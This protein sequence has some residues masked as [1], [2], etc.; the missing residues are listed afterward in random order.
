MSSARIRNARPSTTDIIENTCKGTEILN[1]IHTEFLPKFPRVRSYFNCTEYTSIRNYSWSTSPR[2]FAYSHCSTLTAPVLTYYKSQ[3]DSQYMN[4]PQMHHLQAMKTLLWYLKETK[5]YRMLYHHHLHNPT[6][7]LPTIYSDANF[8]N[9]TNCKSI[10]GN[11]RLHANKPIFRVS[12]SQNVVDH[13]NEYHATYQLT[14]KFLGTS[15]LTMRNN[16][17]PSH[18]QSVD[19]INCQPPSYSQMH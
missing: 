7:S 14:P 8:V 6:Q 13:N 18:R 5:S 4:K 16:N 2:L 3:I 1:N 9:T 19:D 15:L 12:N 10:T 11:L 17:Y